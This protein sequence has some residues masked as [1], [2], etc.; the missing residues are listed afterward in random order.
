MLLVLSASSA[1][2]QPVQKA[3]ESKVTKVTVFPEG[4]QVSRTAKT[5]ISPG[6]TELTF[7]GLS[8]YTSIS[9]I[10]VSGI[11]PFS[12]ISVSPVANKLK[13]QKKRKEIAEIEKSKEGLNKL[14][15]QD[16]A[17][18]DVYMKEEQMLASNYVVGGANTGLKAADLTAALDVHRARLRELKFFEIDYNEKIKK[19]QDTLSMI[20]AQI[21]VSNGK[22][23]L[24]TLDVVVTVSSKEQASGD[25]TLG[26]VVGNAGWFPTYDLRVDDVTKPLLVDYK[27]NVYQNTGEE[28]KD[29][30]LTFSNGNP[31]ESG[32]APILNPLVLRNNNYVYKAPVNNRYPINPNIREVTGR[33]TDN[34]GEPLI[35]A[36]IMVM[37]STV[38]TVTDYSGNYV[39]HIPP[40]SS[41]VRVSLVGYQPQT[42][43]IYSGTLNI[44][45]QES[46][47]MLDQVTVSEYRESFY[48]NAPAQS[49]GAMDLKSSKNY[50]NRE[51]ATNVQ[52][53]EPTQTNTVVTFELATP[54]TIVN[55][56][57]TRAV[58]MKQ[59]EMPASFEHFCVPKME[60]KAYLVAHIPGWI[61]YNL[62]EG[63][64]NLYY[65][66]TYL[67]KTLFSLSEASD[68]LHLSLGVDK[69]I[70]VNRTKVKD[71][72]K[73][74]VLSDKKIVASAYELTF[75]NN[76]K[77]PVNMVVE[78][79]VPI[80][81]DKEITVSDQTYEGATLDEATGKLTW[82]VI[83]DP[84]KDKKLKLSYTVKYP[85]TYNVQTD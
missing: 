25:F 57:K 43:S 63:E 5:T 80:S 48:A 82:K 4:A 34:K 1:I 81:A 9:S 52:Y 59:E 45:M 55:D 67:G 22:G 83:L 74:Q 72:S 28:W 36:T 18:L 68:T 38:G 8:P 21:R 13:E 17:S 6:T 62:L 26:Y 46:A 12:I 56:G 33:I 19:L 42:L 58:D 73:K 29:V 15:T 24:S 30:K 66:G 44:V 51:K 85:K 79:Q 14:L 37:G 70:T 61:D 10:Q 69:G 64:V 77:F 71:F 39:V 84:G 47:K 75:R 7:S 76:R 16:K 23:D 35:G 41:Q 20:D 27:A 60:K 78:D 65:E 2:A 3:V 11:G 49:M 53:A 54:Y 50:L 31:N 32:V 40:G